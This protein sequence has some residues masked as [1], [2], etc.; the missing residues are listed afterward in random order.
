LEDGLSEDGSPLALEDGDRKQMSLVGME[1]PAD[2]SADKDAAGGSG[3]AP[4]APS[5]SIKR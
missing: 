4:P 3:T 1:D 2:S 5:C